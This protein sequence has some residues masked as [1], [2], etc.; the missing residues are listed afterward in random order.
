MKEEEEKPICY[1]ETKAFLSP[2]V[3]LHVGFCTPVP[4]HPLLFLT[5]YHLTT[6]EAG[7]TRRTLMEKASK[8]ATWRHCFPLLLG[9][10][11]SG[12]RL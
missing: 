2:P 3:L 9:S 10:V 6:V 12:V 11:V 5:W 1:L 4:V 8:K 7:T